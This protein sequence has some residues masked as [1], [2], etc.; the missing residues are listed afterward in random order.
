MAPDS[1]ERLVRAVGR[2]LPNAVRRRYAAKF[3]LAFLVVAAVVVAGGA[4]TY[5]Q[6]EQTVE[7][8]TTTQLAETGGL[9]AD[10]IGS[11]TE[12]MSTETR[13][14]SAADALRSDRRAPA[15]VLLKDQLLSEDIVSIHL[16]DAAQDR[17][18]AS[19]ERPLEGRAPSDLDAP[20]SDADVPEGVGEDD[21]VWRSD[22]SYRSP[23][24]NDRPVMAFASSVPRADGRY[25]VVVT[26]IQPQLERIQNSDT[27]E[28]TMILNAAG[29]TVLDIDGTVDE[30]EHADGVEAIRE[31]NAT[32]ATRIGDGQVHAYASVPDTDWVAVTSV[33][34]STAFAVRNDVGNSVLLLIFLTLASLGVVGAVLGTRTVLPLSR[35]RNR[36]ERIESGDLDVDLST[37][38]IDEIGRRFRSCGEMRDSLRDRIAEAETAADEAEAARGEAEAVTRDMEARAADYSEVMGAVADGDLTR[39]MDPDAD[40]EAMREI[41]EEFNDMVAQLERTTAR[42]AAF[43]GEVDGASAELAA[44]AD[45]VETASGTVSEQIQEIADGAISQDERLDEVSDEMSDLS[46]SIEEVASSA[47]SVAETAEAAA[48]RGESGREAASE[49][50]DEMDA[51]EARSAAA[52]EQMEALDERM[53]EIDEVVEFITDV[54]EQTNILALNASIEAARAGEAGEGFAVVADEVKELAEETQEAAAEIESQIA[55]VREET[56]ATVDDIRETNE[57]IDEGADTVRE[58]SSSLEAVVDAVE[59]TNHGVQEISEAAEDQARS[60]QRAVEGVEDVAEVS[61]EVAAGSE[62]VSAAAEEQTATV[63]TIAENADRLRGQAE[64]LSESV[65]AFDVDVDPEEIESAESDGVDGAEGDDAVGGDERRDAGNGTVG[66]ADGSPSGDGLAA[67]GDGRPPSSDER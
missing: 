63:A 64:S 22:R 19:T 25:L 37:G 61:G 14:M 42:V 60:T 57:R 38:R 41:A 4:F 62:Q 30:A 23:V 55:T 54:A 15:Y 10:A 35:L 44:G 1:F 58:A 47:A 5:L 17:V 18:V 8:D 27:G 36:A 34:Q 53:D 43:A 31:G 3:A 39:R 67:D 26:R 21:R 65:S 13:S 56:D 29:Q 50:L 7:S 49:A 59:E 16:V 52:V 9:Q 48:E 2:L 40:R 28:E 51:I 6:T 32:T 66:D 33:D 45:E 11:W 46:A 20:W 24:L 12:R